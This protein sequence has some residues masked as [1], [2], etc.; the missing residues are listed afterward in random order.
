MYQTNFRCRS[1]RIKESI[2]S[3]NRISNIRML[4]FFSFH[5]MASVAI[6]VQVF[7]RFRLHHSEIVHDSG[8]CCGV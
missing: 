2:E 1:L 8:F 3:H 4:R 6:V 5:Y 7:H